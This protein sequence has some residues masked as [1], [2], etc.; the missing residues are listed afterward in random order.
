MTTQQVQADAGADRHRTLSAG[1]LDQHADFL[2]NLGDL[3]SSDHLTQYP[4]LVD[5]KRRTRPQQTTNINRFSQFH[6]RDSHIESA[7]GRAADSTSSAVPPAAPRQYNDRSFSCNTHRP[8]PS[9]AMLNDIAT[10]LS[11]RQTTCRYELGESRRVAGGVGGRRVF[12]HSAG[13]RTE[14]GRLRMVGFPTTGSPRGPRNR[15]PGDRR[16]RFAHR[17][18]PA[19]GTPSPAPAFRTPGRPPD[20]APPCG[21]RPAGA[22]PRVAAFRP[23]APRR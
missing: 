11:T 22:A 16:C 18:L 20:Q 13:G 3:R 15:Q 2:A 23:R 14:L 12:G 17:C 10:S 4:H 9:L 7:K 19:R 1:F 8:G 5:P 6:G 21:L